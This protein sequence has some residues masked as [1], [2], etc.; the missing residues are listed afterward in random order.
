MKTNGEGKACNIIYYILLHSEEIWNYG[1]LGTIS[2]KP[3]ILKVPITMLKQ[4][5]QMLI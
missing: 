4:R 2:E 5:V 3:T 1:F